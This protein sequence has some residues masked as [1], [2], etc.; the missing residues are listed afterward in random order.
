M[1]Q[2]T[3]CGE[4]SFSGVGLHSGTTVEMSLCPAPEGYGIR[5]QRTD[6]P[7]DPV[8]EALAVYVA[9][10]E[11]RTV[12]MRDQ[13]GISTPEHLLAALYGM[14]VDNV[15]VKLN[16]PEVPILDGSAYPFAAGIKA[17]GVHEQKAGREYI[18]LIHPVHFSDKNSGTTIDVVPSSSFSARVI[19]DFDSGVLG[20]QE[21]VFNQETDFLSAVACSWTFVF[22]HEVLPLF[23]KGLIRGGDLDNALV[24]ED[25]ELSEQDLFQL[26]KMFGKQGL[27]MHK[28]YLNEAEL[29]FPDECARHK[30]VDLLGDLFLAGKRFNASVTAYKPGHASNT[31]VALMISDQMNGYDT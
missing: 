31:A 6:I 1:K 28:G 4:I 21:F 19:L 15:L 26:R 25:K 12:L 7:G 24:I 14:G 18:D 3:I 17:T 22:L 13:V 2:Q 8:V 23:E 10:T 16:G 5:F 30:M 29:R 27:I 20:K 11:R 9:K